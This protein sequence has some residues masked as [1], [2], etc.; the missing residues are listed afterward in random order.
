MILLEKFKERRSLGKNRICGQIILKRI[1]KFEW[2]EVKWI[3]VFQNGDSGFAFVNMLM[4]IWFHKRGRKVFD[5][6]KK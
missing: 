6:M 1:F 4:N 2:E 5:Y 3:R